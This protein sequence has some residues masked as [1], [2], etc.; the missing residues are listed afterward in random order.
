MFRNKNEQQERKWEPGVLGESIH[1]RRR[2]TEPRV[3]PGD[4]GA[5]VPPVAGRDLVLPLPI[6]TNVKISP[7]LTRTASVRREK[8]YSGLVPLQGC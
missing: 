7:P 5:F 4:R 3:P 1:Q 2:S 8:P 6:N